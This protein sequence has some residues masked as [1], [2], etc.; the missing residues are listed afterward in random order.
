MLSLRIG[1]A[2]L[3]L[4]VATAGC[5]DTDDATEVNVA[6]APHFSQE[7]MEAGDPVPGATLRLYTAETIVLE[8]VVDD[9]GSAFIAPDPGTYDVQVVLASDDPGCFWGETA[10]GV[11]FPSS[12]VT[13]EVGF[14]CAGA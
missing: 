11:R 3:V 7:G 2:L 9:S 13:I 4:L 8:T 6:V 12:L 1:G 5:S 14:I 10:F